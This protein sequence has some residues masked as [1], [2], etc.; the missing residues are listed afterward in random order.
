MEVGF[1]TAPENGLGGKSL[2]PG[3]MIVRLGKTGKRLEKN[4]NIYAYLTT[5]K[6]IKKKITP[7][8]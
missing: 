8:I 4:V 2:P 3:F 7:G 1:I 5:R 6:R